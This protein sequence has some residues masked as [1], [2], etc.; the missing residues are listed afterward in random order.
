MTTS[1]V[2]K[3]NLLQFRTAKCWYLFFYSETLKNPN[4]KIKILNQSCL[5]WKQLQAIRMIIYTLFHHQNKYSSSLTLKWLKIIRFWVITL[6]NWHL[7][8]WCR[9]QE[10]WVSINSSIMVN[11][12]ITNLCLSLHLLTMC[13]K[14]SD[15][16]I[17]RISTI[18]KLMLLSNFVNKDH[19]VSSINK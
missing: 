18:V 13:S 2:R 3:A 1:Y 5:W 4:V 6:Y 16:S 8:N 15:L 14:C 10:Y 7:Y 17:R 11:Q 9:K 12:T 19:M